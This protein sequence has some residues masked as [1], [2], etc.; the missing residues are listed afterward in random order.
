MKSIIRVS[1]TL[2]ILTFSTAVSAKVNFRDH[3]TRAEIR[4][5][6]IQDISSKFPSCAQFPSL[7]TESISLPYPA[8]KRRLNVLHASAELNNTNLSSFR[9]CVRNLFQDHN[10]RFASHKNF[11]YRSLL[12]R[13][14]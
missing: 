4:S 9:S 12:L 5:A 6:A 13:H 14:A 2:M 7:I 8:D 10:S 1:F 11:E 3:P